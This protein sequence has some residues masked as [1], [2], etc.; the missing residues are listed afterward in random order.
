MIPDQNDRLESR[1]GKSD[2]GPTTVLAWS[3]DGP[4]FACLET[5]DRPPADAISLQRALARSDA[6]CK[7]SAYLLAAAGHDLRQPLQVISM[8]LDGLALGLA[9][10]R[11]GAWL[12]IARGE[13]SNLSADLQDLAFAARLS[14]P[15]VTVLALTDVIRGAADSWRHH[16]A[17]R[18]LELRIRDT[19]CRVRCNPR[20]LATILRNLIGNA[21]KHTTT[22]GV[23][24]GVRRRPD[25]VRIDVIDTGPGVEQ[26]QIARLLEPHQ[27][28]TANAEGLGLG[29]AIVRDAAERLSCG[30]SVRSRSGRG[31][32]FSVTIPN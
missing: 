17:A 9:E 2:G 25:G 27:R 29:L 26:D 11:R 23:L 30:L 3:A 15:A 22:G 6:L 5:P 1:A 21:V 28:G 10:P 8:L 13:I 12:A 16:A 20:L 4:I 24:I 31:S 32:R 18:G 14:E 19:D 7:R